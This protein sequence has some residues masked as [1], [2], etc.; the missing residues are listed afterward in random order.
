MRT[1]IAA[2]LTVAV[3]LTGLVSAAHADAVP[4]PDALPGATR[5]PWVVVADDA[6]YALATVPGTHPDAGETVLFARDVVRETDRVTVG[7]AQVVA[8]L[9]GWGFA[10]HGGDL[11]YVPAHADGLVVRHADG[12]LEEP[13][14]GDHPV[15]TGGA[16]LTSMSDGW[17]AAG[18]LLFERGGSRT[19]DLTEILAETLTDLPAS[20]SSVAIGDVQVTDDVALVHALVDQRPTVQTWGWILAAVPLGEGGPSGPAITLSPDVMLPVG[21]VGDRL[22]WVE[23]WEVLSAPVSQPD[24]APTFLADVSYDLWHVTHDGEDV[25]VQ[26]GRGF[27]WPSTLE[28]LDPA[29]VA[30]TEVVAEFDL[31]A[32]VR[33]GRDGLLAVGYEPVGLVD[34]QGRE[35]VADATPVAW[36]ATF[37]DVP[38]SHP[39]RPQVHWLVDA[40][41]TTGYEDGTFRPEAP[42]SRQAM[43]AFLHR[44]A[45]SPATTGAPEFADVG[46]SHPFRQPVAWLVDAGITTGYEDGTFRPTAPVTRQAMAAFL[47]RAAGE[48]A[49]EAPATSPFT[50]LGP[51]APFYREVAW[52]AS[53]GITTGYADGG[54]H[55]G[56]PVSRQA[57]A[58]FLQRAAA[59]GLG[60]TG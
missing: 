55:P 58:A 8:R 50:D 39:F 56:S 60:P 2:V 29:G 45:G 11:A 10:Q 53:T 40:G 36:P 48:P 5:D 19:F 31:W 42:V 3:G 35:L 32:T 4:R 51:G 30:P 37:V 14:W 57:M 41:V 24:A 21:V 59:A 27:D 38:P 43:A 44:L 22:V 52:L 28:A 1:R 54:F 16:D 9:D 12:A 13:V 20:T 26:Y 49:F 18:G 15:L 7:P 17:L 46:A 34:V 33:A 25:L 47:Y 6:V 23:E